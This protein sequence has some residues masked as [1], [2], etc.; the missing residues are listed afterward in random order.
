MTLLQKPLFALTAGD[1][2]S[3][4]VVTLPEDMSLSAAAHV[5]RREQISGA[6]VID[7]HGRCVGVLSAN[8]FIRR[9]EEEVLPHRTHHEEFLGMEWQGMELEDS[10]LDSVADHMTADPVMVS[11]KVS[12]AQVAEMM[13]E[14]HIHRLI[15]VD[16]ES[17]PVGVVTTT[18]ILAALV[19]ESK[20]AL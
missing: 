12:I 17:R 4:V 16:S 11:R 9:V 2:M 15:V 1:L 19:R 18:D 14:A 6:P 13:L 8:D 20:H 10:E 3:P 5:L 7:R